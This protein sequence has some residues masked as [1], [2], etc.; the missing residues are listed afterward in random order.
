MTLENGAT[1]R[2]N[3]PQVIGSAQRPASVEHVLEKFLKNAGAAMPALQARTLWDALLND[4]ALPS[5]IP[6]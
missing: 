2:A 5:L 4:D 6:S 1:L 3:V